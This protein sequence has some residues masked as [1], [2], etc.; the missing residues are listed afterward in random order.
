MKKTFDNS[1][2][3]LLKRLVIG[4]G[5]I[6]I[7]GVRV[8]TAIASDLPLVTSDDATAK[9]VKYVPDVSKTHD[10]KPGSKCA[11]CMLY[12]GAAGSAQGG[13]ALFPAKAVKASSWCLSWSAK[14]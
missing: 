5:L 9:A 11:N 12:Q 13:C 7:A 8:S 6:P 3:R 10:A 14:A 4:I 2:R 1:R